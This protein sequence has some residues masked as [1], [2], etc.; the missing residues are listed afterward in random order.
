MSALIQTI[1][2]STFLPT[3][4]PIH[5]TAYPVIYPSTL[6]PIHASIH[7]PTHP[8]IL[9]YTI[10]KNNVIATENWLKRISPKMSILSNLGVDE[11]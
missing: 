1:Y 6:P 8:P 4:L 2:L 5:P 3:Y 11:K 9:V 10:Q 7:P